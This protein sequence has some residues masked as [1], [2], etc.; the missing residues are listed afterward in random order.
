MNEALIT[1]VVIED[2]DE[3]EFELRLMNDVVFE[4]RLGGKTVCKGDW[5]NLNK[6]FKRAID[7]WGSVDA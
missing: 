1:T 2:E 4:I 7:L 3:V 5:E 6:L